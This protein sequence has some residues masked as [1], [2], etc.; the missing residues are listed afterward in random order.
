MKKVQ[1][2]KNCG[3]MNHRFWAWYSTM[4]RMLNEPTCTTTPI[5]ARPRNTSYDTVCAEARKLPSR[6]YLLFDDQ[7]ANST[8]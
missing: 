6:A 3:M 2:P 8:A 4:S 5:S 1:K 7:P